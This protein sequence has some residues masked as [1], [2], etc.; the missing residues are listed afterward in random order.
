MTLCWK[1][2]RFSIHSFSS[3]P[4]GVRAYKLQDVREG[5]EA[6]CEFCALLLATV[7]DDLDITPYEPYQ[8]WIRLNFS[9][10]N[11]QYGLGL[12]Y[13]RLH[14]K[15]VN[16]VFPK[17][18]SDIDDGGKEYQLHVAAD[19]GWFP[20]HRNYEGKFPAHCALSKSRSAEWRCD[21]KI[22]WRQSYIRPAHLNNRSMA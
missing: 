21:R 16:T 13:N 14:V 4:D 18:G 17:L 6:G 5:A 20:S 3:D 2:Q 15:V 22:S 10:H 1:C 8:T 9:K 19:P 12:A 7:Q 11:E